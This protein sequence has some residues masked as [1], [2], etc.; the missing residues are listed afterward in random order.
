MQ[1]KPSNTIEHT[2]YNEMENSLFF[3]V[4]FLLVL[5]FVISRMLFALCSASFCSAVTVLAWLIFLF[6]CFFV[7]RWLYAMFFFLEGFRVYVFSF[8]L[9]LLFDVCFGVIYLIF[10]GI[11][12]WTC[13]IVRV[14]SMMTV[15]WTSN[16]YY[17]RSNRCDHVFLVGN[18]MRAVAK[19]VKFK[20]NKKAQNHTHEQITANEQ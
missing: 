20:R 9:C 15:T 1:E 13:A 12:L 10:D 5:L 7:C 6:F 11:V 17:N 16:Y 4:F 18:R 14:K 8:F 19:C 3:F 2:R